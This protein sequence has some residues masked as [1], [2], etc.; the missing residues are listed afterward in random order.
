LW[1]K[2]SDFWIVFG[3]FVAKTKARL[4]QSANDGEEDDNL[5]ELT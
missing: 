4:R 1:Q 3:F 2:F 5:R